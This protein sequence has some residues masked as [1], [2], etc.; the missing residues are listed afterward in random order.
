MTS[1]NVT[2]YTVTHKETGKRWNYSQHAYCRNRIN[3][4]LNSHIPPSDFELIVTWPDEDE[5]EQVIFEG[6]LSDYLK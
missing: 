2:Y 3:E 5:E 1:A 4:N 6:S